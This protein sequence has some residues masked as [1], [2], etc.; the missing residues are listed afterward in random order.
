MDKSN[1]ARPEDAIPLEDGP[2]LIDMMTSL[3]CV[4]EADSND[5]QTR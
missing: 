4:L 1:E 5:S 3:L 2:E